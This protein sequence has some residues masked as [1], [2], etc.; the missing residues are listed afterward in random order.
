MPAFPPPGFVAVTAA[1]ARLW[2]RAGLEA[3]APALL[4]AWRGEADE[5]VGGGR[6]AHPV[7]PAEGGSVVVRRF[8]RGGAIRHLNRDRYFLGDRAA[9][10]LAASEAA[11]HGGVRTP[12]VVALGRRRSGLGYRSMIATRRVPGATDATVQLADPAAREWILRAI[13]DQIASLHASCVT[14]PDLN[15]RNVL[16]DADGRIWLIDFDRARLFTGPVPASQRTKD[17]LRFARSAEKLGH[18]LG[19]EDWA[20]LRAG[21]G[22]DWPVNTRG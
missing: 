9:A 13:G 4:G 14:H 19:P 17:I 22:H 10:E 3:L 18:P 7:I 21:Y 8:L 2:V 6:A 15:V 11:R 16:V 1:P 12:E 5:W 20:A